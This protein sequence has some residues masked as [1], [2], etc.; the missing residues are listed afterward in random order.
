[1]ARANLLGVA[2]ASISILSVVLVWFWR[3]FGLSFGSGET[4]LSRTISGYTA[5]VSALFIVGAFVALL[6]PLGAMLQLPA[7]GFFP[8]VIWWREL[9][10]F[11][12]FGYVVA[13]IGAVVSFGSS[14][15]QITLPGR[16]LRIPPESRIAV[17]SL[18]KDEHQSHPL[19]RAAK[20]ALLSI[21]IVAVLISIW[22]MA[23]AYTQPRSKISVT[24]VIDSR[25]Y[26]IDNVTVEIDDRVVLHKQL[27]TNYTQFQ[28]VVNETAGSHTLSV[29]LA[30][31]NI[32]PDHWHSY[33]PWVV[34]VLPFTTEEVQV[35]YNVIFA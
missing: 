10:G 16:R 8:F 15:V 21:V 20:I 11:W 4:A 6:T 25:G 18:R 35:G 24:V 32:P 19:P 5:E 14:F 29:T 1:M 17:W 30:G 26:E 13:L 34:K 31:D 27:A 12:T 7:L 33:Q 3:F 23:P 9:S 28:V 2:G 22:I